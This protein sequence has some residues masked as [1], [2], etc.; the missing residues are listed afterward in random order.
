[1]FPIQLFPRTNSWLWTISPSG[2]TQKGISP[3]VNPRVSLPPPSSHALHAVVSDCVTAREEEADYLRVSGFPFLPQ[4]QRPSEFS[5]C[6]A[7]RFNFLIKFQ[8][9]MILIYVISL[10]GVRPSLF[11][12]SLPVTY[13]FFTE[14]SA[15][16]CV[17]K[18]LAIPLP[19]CCLWR[20]IM[21]QGTSSARQTLFKIRKINTGVH[22]RT[23]QW[24]EKNKKSNNLRNMI[25]KS[26]YYKYRS[27]SVPHFNLLCVY[28]NMH[29][30]THCTY[31]CVDVI[32]YLRFKD[33]LFPNGHIRWWYLPLTVM[34]LAVNSS[35]GGSL[36]SSSFGRR[37]VEQWNRRD[38]SALRLVE[39][40]R[41]R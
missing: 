28:K 14:Q 38:L 8:F 21:S 1:M 39:L 25:H 41:R 17:S 31:I 6:A 35:S 37:H 3:S 19:H 27:S 24:G 40:S 23:H 22:T 36:R 29:T 15:G 11:F 26:V 7:S 9:E 20:R 18:P 34:A 32:I 5:P 13:K 12:G 4:A 30:H 2:F 33:S 16:K 10:D